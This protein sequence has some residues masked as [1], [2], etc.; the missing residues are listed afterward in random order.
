MATGHDMTVIGKM[1]TC[2]AW[3]LIIGS[4]VENI[5]VSGTM[6]ICMVKGFILGRTAGNMKGTIFDFKKFLSDFF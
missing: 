6:V 3:V 2:M 1:I 4:M 5:K